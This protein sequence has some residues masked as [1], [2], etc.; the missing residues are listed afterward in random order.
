MASLGAEHDAPAGLWGIHAHSGL[1]F[2]GLSCA[3]SLM[4][5]LLAGERRGRAQLGVVASPTVA[6]AAAPASADAP[7]AAAAHAGRV[8]EDGDLRC[9]AHLGTPE[10][11]RGLGMSALEVAFVLKAMH[12]DERALLPCVLAAMGLELAVTPDKLADDGRRSSGA[13]RVR[14]SGA[15]G[16]D[17]EALQPSLGLRWREAEGGSVAAVCRM[18]GVPQTADRAPVGAD[19]STLLS[20][21]E[22]RGL[23]AALEDAFD[24]ADSIQFGELLLCTVKAALAELDESLPHVDCSEMRAKVKT[25]P[26]VAS[27]DP[28]MVPYEVSYQVRL[29]S[30]ALR[31]RLLKL[32]AP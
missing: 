20:E 8:A 7:A 18:L 28:L 22:V 4:D 5:L 10:R 6:A 14:A 32:C 30:P 23:R 31:C 2:S 19:P 15:A 27:G 13:E 16:D 26:V 1:P 12:R 24:G 11:G 17:A 3:I 25:I 9:E 21:A 29:H